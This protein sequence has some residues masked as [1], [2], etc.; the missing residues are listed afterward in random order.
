MLAGFAV[1][2]AQRRMLAAFVSFYL[3]LNVEET[4]RFE[5]EVATW[6]HQLTD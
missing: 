1:T 4:C 5:A 2:V 3:P 6:Q